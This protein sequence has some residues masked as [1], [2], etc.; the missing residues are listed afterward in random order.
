MTVFRRNFG[1][2]TKKFASK[3]K[4]FATKKEIFASK[5]SEKETKTVL[6]FG[7][8]EFGRHHHC[9]I[10]QRHNDRGACWKVSFF[11]N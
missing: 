2:K 11:L 9:Y 4:I 8:S 6:E 10:T 3:K 1:T 5:F 7:E